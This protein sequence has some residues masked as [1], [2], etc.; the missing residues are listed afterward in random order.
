MERKT[1]IF[2]EAFRLMYSGFCQMNGIFIYDN[3]GNVLEFIARYNLDTE[4]DK[5]F[6]GN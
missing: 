1:A 2:L 5:K 4:S 6:D 3:N